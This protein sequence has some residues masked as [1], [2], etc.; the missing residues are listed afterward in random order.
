MLQTASIVLL[1]FAVSLDSFGVGLNYGLRQIKIPR[2]SIA[3]IALCS[4]LMMLVAML[5]GSLIMPLVPE[6]I[7]RWTGGAILIFIGLWAVLQMLLRRKE[8]GD[9]RIGATAVGDTGDRSEGDSGAAQG[10]ITTDARV[11]QDFAACDPK[12]VWRVE[13]RSLGIVIEILRT[14]SSADM[15]RSGTISPGEAALL[16]TALSLDAFGAGIGAAFIGMSPWFTSGVIA[17]FCAIFLRLG[18]GVGTAAAGIS[19]VRRLTLLP[20]FILIALGLAK[21][22][23]I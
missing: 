3:I 10:P 12:R 13:L 4:G 16:G 8:N 17:I 6:Q 20:G 21:I 19:W 9:D 1:A 14:P 15:D 2:I 7:V 11:V 18:I 22:L 23:Q 5:L